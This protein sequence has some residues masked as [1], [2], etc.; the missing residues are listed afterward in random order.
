MGTQSYIRNEWFDQECNDILQEKNEARERML[1]KETR[2][3]CEKYKNL[4][5]QANKFC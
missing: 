4:R 1:Q 5:L 3:N 2:S